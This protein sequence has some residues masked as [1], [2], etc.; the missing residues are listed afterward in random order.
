MKIAQ[1]VIAR[2]ERATFVETSELTQTVR[3]SG[4]FGSTGLKQQ[5]DRPTENGM[6]IA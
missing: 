4:G 5:S 1:M 2:H 6:K 3:G